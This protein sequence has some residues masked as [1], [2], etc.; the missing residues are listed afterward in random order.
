[1]ASWALNQHGCSSDTS[2]LD[3]TI[4]SNGLDDLSAAGIVLYPVPV[5]EVLQV[6]SD[7]DILEIE[8]VDLN[9]REVHTARGTSVDLSFLESG[10]YLVRIWDLEGQLL[11]TR[12]ILKE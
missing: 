1:V 12:K 6:Q 10:I 5:K 2:Y 4:G 3:V 7:L 11:G 9:G 8:V